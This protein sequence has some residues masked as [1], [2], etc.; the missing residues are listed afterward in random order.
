VAGPP[1]GEALGRALDFRPVRAITSAAPHTT[2]V[3]SKD[4]DEA[5]LQTRVKSAS[6]L[7]AEMF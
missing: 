3:A 7:S 1:F 4:H 5:K 6:A 2:P